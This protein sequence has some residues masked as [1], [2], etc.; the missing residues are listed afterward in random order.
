METPQ[1]RSFDL[2]WRHV[3]EQWPDDASHHAFLQ[4]CQ[5]ERRL[6]DAAAR[7]RGMAGDHAR[8]AVAEKQLHKI[9]V[10]ALS[11]METP[12]RTPPPRRSRLMVLSAFAF[13]GLA[14]VLGYL[15]LF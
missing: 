2:L 9:L 11:E 6:A 13:F 7:Y 15:A 4:V 10:L 3:L 12:Q 8:R 5:S 14:L 1:E